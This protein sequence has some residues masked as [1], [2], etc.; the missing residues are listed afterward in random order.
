MLLPGLW[1]TSTYRLGPDGICSEGISRDGIRSDGIS[2]YGI[3]TVILDYQVST[4][5]IVMLDSVLPVHIVMV[6]SGFEWRCFVSE[7]I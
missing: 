7:F 4:V 6:I 3:R 5:N 2:S 1:T